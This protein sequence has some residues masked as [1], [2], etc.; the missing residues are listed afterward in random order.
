M[1][2][3]VMFGES[4]II[5]HLELRNEAPSIDEIQ[6]GLVGHTMD[7][8]ERQ[9]NLMEFVIAGNKYRATCRGLLDFYASEWY[10]LA[11]S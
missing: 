2:V 10:V 4:G 6:L 3:R 7:I 9:G 1:N 5:R 11:F 8:G